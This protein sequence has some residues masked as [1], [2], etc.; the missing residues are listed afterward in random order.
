MACL[1]LV[2][3][4]GFSACTFHSE[5]SLRAKRLQDKLAAAERELAGLED[6]MKDPTIESGLKDRLATERELMKSRIERIR[7][8]LDQEGDSETAQ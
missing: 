7:E 5:P 3:A 8:N 2:L 4:T 1:F 6:K